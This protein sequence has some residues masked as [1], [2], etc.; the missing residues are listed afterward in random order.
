MVN[1]E[2]I[3]QMISKVF[4]FPLP[5][6]IPSNAQ[7]L[8]AVNWGRYNGPDQGSVSPQPLHMEAAGFSVFLVP[9]YQMI[10]HYALEYHNFS[11]NPILQNT[12]PS[13]PCTHMNQILILQEHFITYTKPETT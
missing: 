2:T 9:I 12:G 1:K 6:I 4:Y 5:I 7:Y 10:Q 11:E 13:S 3:V 8:L